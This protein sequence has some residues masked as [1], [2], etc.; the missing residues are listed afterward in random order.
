M[1]LYV[2]ELFITLILQH[3]LEECNFVIAP[4]IGPDPINDRGAPLDNERLNAILLHQVGV[5]ELFHGLN[6]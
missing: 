1:Q 2:P 6:R 3:F 4:S 5:H